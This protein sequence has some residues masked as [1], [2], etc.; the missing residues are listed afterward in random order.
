MYYRRVLI[1]LMKAQEDATE[2]QLRGWFQRDSSS[3]K[4]GAMKRSSI[5]L[6]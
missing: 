5:S 6:E 1:G 4:D 3:S 2:G